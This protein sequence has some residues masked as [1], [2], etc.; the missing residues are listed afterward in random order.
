MKYSKASGPWRL[1]IEAGY[2]EHLA[3]ANNSL[4]PYPSKPS[5]SAGQIEHH[6]FAEIQSPSLDA[7]RL[8][9]RLQDLE[10][11]SGGQQSTLA[12][13][14]RS[15]RKLHDKS[16]LVS[17]S[18]ATRATDS[19]IKRGKNPAANALQYCRSIF[20]PLDHTLFLQ[21][22]GLM[23]RLTWFLDRIPMSRT[24]ILRQHSLK[25]TECRPRL[26]DQ[27]HQ[28]SLGVMRPARTT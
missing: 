26:K 12:L 13:T 1:R 16:D 11:A 19:S 4:F 23:Y 6:R 9:I 7:D 18:R 27:E 24:N 21:T 22:T 25:W 20:Q 5:V 15:P 17:H 2:Q 14:C 10:S 28:A 8:S 3:I